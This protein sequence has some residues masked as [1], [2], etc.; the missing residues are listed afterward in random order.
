MEIQHDAPTLAGV[1]PCPSCK[2]QIER[3]AVLCI[4][5]GY[6]LASGQKI[7]KI[8]GIAAN[9]NLIVLGGG[10]LV[11]MILAAAFLFW[12]ESDQPPPPA[13]PAPAPVASPP[14]PAVVPEPNATP[15][16]VLSEPPPPPSPSPE[17][18]AAQKAEEE[19]LA[20]EAEA[21]R[22]QAERAAFEAKKAQAE[23]AL[24]RQ[25]EIREPLH[26][27]GD[28]VELRRKNGFIQKGELQRFSGTGTNRVA[29]VATATGEI[30][31]PHV[32][33][34]PPSRRRMDPNYHEAYKQHVMSTRGPATPGTPPA[35]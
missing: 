10:A 20:R 29:V 16:P 34:D 25:M 24:R 15:A 5:C 35:E 7:A 13:A 9:R 31:I 18:I 26:K 21:E 2:A 19:R 12:P 30:G 17:E 11:V 33:L 28:T 32:T 27:L 14:P 1:K 3:D 6:N 22:L 4:H 8:N 23:Q